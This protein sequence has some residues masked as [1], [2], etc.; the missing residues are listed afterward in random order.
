MTDRHMLITGGTGFLGS[1]ICERALQE[2]YQVSVLTRDAGKAKK[3]LPA[4][5]DL[6]E[7]LEDLP[8]P[9]AIDVV[10]NMAGESLASG[11]WNDKKKQAFHDS[12]VGFT[13]DLCRFFLK[14]KVV[15][16]VLISGSAIGFY[17]PQSDKKLDEASHPR[18]GFSHQLCRA[19]ENEAKKLASVGTRVVLLRTG[20]VLDRQQGA[21]AKM[22]PAFRLGMGGKLGSGKQ[23]MSWIH[24]DDY[25]ELIFHCIARSDIDQQVN[26][27]APEPVTNGVFT[28][29]LGKVLFRPTLFAM[30]AVV[31]R[32]VFGEMA[33]ELL[34]SGQRVYPRKALDSG[35]SFRFETLEPALRDILS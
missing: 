30:P 29:T 8:D 9:A 22:L 32:G 28:K 13:R 19:W 33:D 35:F 14:R 15:P 27:T 17:G 3:K 31:A 25:V 21:L 10:V 24:I 18:Q 5:V 4:E 34:L 7:S 1:K 26:G 6:Y 16:K 2:G 23:W 11:R 20:V 12:R